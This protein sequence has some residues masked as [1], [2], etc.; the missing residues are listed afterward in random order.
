[1]TDTEDYSTSMYFDEADPVAC[2]D[3]KDCKNVTWTEFITLLQQVYQ[4]SRKLSNY[5]DNINCWGWVDGLDEMLRLLSMD[6]V[7]WKDECRYCWIEYF[8]FDAGGLPWITGVYFL[9]RMDVYARTMKVYESEGIDV[10]KKER[11]IKNLYDIAEV[12]QKNR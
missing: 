8:L 12:D 10:A 5:V 11:W 2:D 6:G 4:V 9:K 1:M 3:H 7:A